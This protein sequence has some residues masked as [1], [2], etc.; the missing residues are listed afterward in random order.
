MPVDLLA[1]GIASLEKCLFRSSVYLSIGLFVFLLLSCVSYLYILEIKPLLVAL[2]ASIFSQFVGCL[3]ILFMVSFA[4]QKLISLIR[5]HVFIFPFIYIALGD[6][7]KK[8]LVQFML[9]N[10][11][12]MFSSRSF[13]VSCLIFKSLSHFEFIFVY[14]VRVCFNFTDLHEASSFPNT[15]CWRD[16]LF[17]IVYSCLFCQR[18]IDHRCV[19]LF[20]GS[21]F[22]WK[23]N[24]KMWHDLTTGY[25]KIH[26]QATIIQEFD[27]C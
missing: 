23:F 17:P 12:P 1:I 16:C 21:L 19:G 26:K 6:W 5:S 8:I 24:F 2:F 13:M 25:T 14:G 4:V 11:L 22:C 15:S 27:L 9:E 18:L 10:V 7:P 3:F 20:L